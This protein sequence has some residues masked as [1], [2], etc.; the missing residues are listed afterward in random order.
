MTRIAA[1]LLQLDR[2]PPS[3]WIT[4]SGADAK[5][6]LPTKVAGRVVE[7]SLTVGV[8]SQELMNGI[9]SQRMAKKTGK[10]KLR[11][12]MLADETSAA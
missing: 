7:R 2:C 10:K 11:V 4:A 3:K 5:R 1:V 8:D 9:R 6:H 12:I